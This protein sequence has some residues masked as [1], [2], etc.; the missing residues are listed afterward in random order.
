MRSLPRVCLT[1]LLLTGMVVGCSADEPAVDPTGSP[2]TSAS[3]SDAG[4]RPWPAIPGERLPQEEGVALRREMD[5]WAREGFVRGA[6]AAVVSPRGV[7]SSATGVDGA[8]ATLDARS[9]MALGE[10]TMTFVAAELLLLA[11]RGK[12]DL[13]RPASTYLDSPLLTNGATVRQLLGHR[14]GVRGSW[15]FDAVKAKPDTRSTPEQL[16][17]TAKTPSTSPGGEY[18]YADENYVLLGLLAAKVGGTDLATLL[19]RDLWDPLGLGRLALQ[20]AQVMAPPLAAPGADESLPASAR[21]HTWVPF[22][23]IVGA[24]G[25]AGGAAGDAE[26]LARWGYALYG[27][28]QLHPESVAEMTDFTEDGHYGLGTINF[29]D[30]YWQNFGM[31]G[32]GHVGGMPGYRSV[33]AVYPEQHLSIAILVPSTV[34]AHPFVRQLV[35]AAKLLG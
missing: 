20:D 23:S 6:T 30:G 13:D 22:R 2:S 12:V 31:D 4:G 3:A 29:A 18:R 14:S 19:R 16:L 35:T 24:L 21:D 26:S 33:L 15:D 8:G 17:A 10:I 9:G 1:V 25:G 32:V 34:D 11:E 27:G 7:W 5:R 28:L